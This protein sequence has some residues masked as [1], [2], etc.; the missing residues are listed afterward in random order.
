MR[1]GLDMPDK[2]EKVFAQIAE[3]QGISVDQLIKRSMLT[4]AVLYERTEDGKHPIIIK[5]SKEKIE[6]E[7]KF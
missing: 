7:F 1:I 4:Y 2:I 3:K 5:N 6:L